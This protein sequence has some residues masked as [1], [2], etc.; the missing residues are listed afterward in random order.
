ML[1][2]LCAANHTVVMMLMPVLAADEL[3]NIKG[4]VTEP[5]GEY[6]ENF[7]ELPLD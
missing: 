5:F 7:E 2:V 1:K 6:L 3:F 4:P